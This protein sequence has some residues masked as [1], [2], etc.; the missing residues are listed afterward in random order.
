M[1]FSNSLKYN[2]VPEWQ[3]HY[4]NYSQLKRLIYSLQAQDLRV[5]DE[6]GHVDAERLKAL[7]GTSKALQKFKNKFRRN[8]RG[9]NNGQSKSKDAASDI[10]GDV[11]V[12]TL[13]LDDFRSSARKNAGKAA[14]FDHRSSLSSD[15]TLFNP[16][17]TFISKLTDER[18]KIDSFYEQ[19]E[20]QL[21][22][23]FDTLLSDL[24]K[25]TGAGRRT[26]VVTGTG[27]APSVSH[28]DGMDMSES[29]VD[30]PSHT[31]RRESV[32]SRRSTAIADLH[33]EGYEQEDEEDEEEEDDFDEHHEN[34]ALLNYSDFNVKSQKRA[35]LKRNLIDLYVDLAQ[36]KSFIELNR[37]GFLKI[38]KKFDKTLNC[39]IKREFIE[40][41][42]FFADTY[43]FQPHTLEN[44]DSHIMQLVES[45][46][47]LTHGDLVASKE[48][49]RSYLRDFIV[50]ERNTVW[51]D[52]LGL[53]SHNNT[54]TSAGRPDVN[55]DI[56]NLENNTHL[57]YR[58]WNLP[59]PIKIRSLT[60]STIKVPELFFTLKA[61][62]LYIIIACTIILLL[63]PTFND[64]AQ[65]RCM[66]LVACVAFLWAS[67]ALPLFVTAILVPMF[68]V[69]FK[70]VK[71]SDGQIMDA[72]SASSWILSKMWSS[73]IM[74]L[75][76][77]FT[78]AAALSKYN[79]AKVLASYLLT[80]AGTKPRNVLL[81]TMGVC[82]FL[83]MWISNVAAPVLT[84]SLIQPVLKTLEYNSP[85]ARSLVLGVALSA[86]VGGM[87]SPISS[88]QNII[89]MNYLKPYNVGWGQFFAIALPSSIL[90]ML[91]IW[92]LLCL[93]FK[94]HGT[95][96][97][98]YTPIKERFTLKQYYVIVVSLAT[99]ILWCVESKIEDVFGA[100]GEIAVIPIV[101]FFG[102]GLLSTQDIN[103]FPWS[104]VILAM[105]GIALG[106]AVQ[107]SGLLA[108][109]AGALQRRVMDFPIYA[110]LIIFGVVML[111]V[112]TFVSHTVSAIIIVP[113]MQE[114]GDKL[115]GKNS[116]PIL[117]F[118]CTLLASC[119]MGLASSGFPNVTAI[120]MVDEVGNRYLSVNTFLTRG[121][122][123]SFLAFL[124][125]IT[126]GY[127]I[128]NSVL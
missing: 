56:A 108:T 34:T 40:S 78:L 45:Y 24:Q 84:Y 12:E 73:T 99:I 38:S 18:A 82:F 124:C 11:N 71:T 96:L 125:V 54:F 17:D 115:P 69:V 60:W 81:M 100:S 23:R 41:G 28:N 85:F 22:G 57:E 20:A 4:L 121:I 63:V 15:R 118:G 39:N 14:A 48:E 10:E 76:A 89:A 68:V 9:N 67:E 49:L 5:I 95:P 111:V 8:E 33:R 55:G 80:V 106:G 58:I 116:A 50:W 109:I 7:E 91:T 26:S 120:S 52:M 88:P 31:H 103:N 74:I 102:T 61:L 104:I 92:G 123:A 44:L 122:P 97:K 36:L 46:A 112:G 51:K 70:V 42:D 21:Y 77:G 93:T 43:V 65:H 105:G 32:L 119:G 16:Q 101:L 117:V 86:N 128:M 30:G 114:V 98:K 59:R 64:R 25:V 19:L 75:L 6:G 87:A 90:S 126:L 1:K 37:I 83:S 107:S 29:V 47:L 3:E 53:E 79:V 110:V 66:A 2:A 72:A 94:I 62:K 35:I 113:L 27:R 13:E 127:G